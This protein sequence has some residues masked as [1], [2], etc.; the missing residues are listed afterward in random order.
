[1]LQG[2][3]SVFALLFVPLYKKPKTNLFWVFLIS[4]TFQHLSA[5]R[6][7]LLSAREILPA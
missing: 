4:I 5:L 7:L 6:A 1:M 2:K 3:G